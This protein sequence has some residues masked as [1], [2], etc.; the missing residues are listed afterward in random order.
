MAEMVD[1]S[2]NAAETGPCV[3]VELVG[4]CLVSRRL[5]NPGR[6]A[7]TLVRVLDLR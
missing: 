4:S 1:E 6:N 5:G 3:R 2:G 7:H